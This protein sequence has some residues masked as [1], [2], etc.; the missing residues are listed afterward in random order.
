MKHVPHIPFKVNRAVADKQVVKVVIGIRDKLLEIKVELI[1]SLDF[2]IDRYFQET[3]QIYSINLCQLN[4]PL[5]LSTY[6]EIE[7]VSVNCSVEIYTC[8]F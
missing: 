4:Q 3:V 2:A 6:S 7:N 8:D 5:V 1:R